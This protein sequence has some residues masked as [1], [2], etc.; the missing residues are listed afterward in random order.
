VSLQSRSKSGSSG[1]TMSPCRR[2]VPLV[3]IQRCREVTLRHHWTVCRCMRRLHTGYQNRK[4]RRES[5]Y[6]VRLPLFSEE[7]GTN[8]SKSDSLPR[9]PHLGANCGCRF[10]VQDPEPDEAGGH[11]KYRALASALIP[12]PRDSAGL[13]SYPPGKQVLAR[14]PETTTFYKAE[15]IATKVGY[16]PR[17]TLSFLA[18]LNLLSSAR[19]Y[20]SAQV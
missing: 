13:P 10:E 11:G 14:Y 12:I 3:A 17:L 8:G 4:T 18:I 19:W 9:S 15:V 7:R 20:V 5:G 2:T 1:N 16:L 6:S